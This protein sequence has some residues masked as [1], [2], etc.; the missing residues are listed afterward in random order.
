MGPANSVVGQTQDVE[1]I[2]IFKICE[3]KKRKIKFQEDEQFQLRN[4]VCSPDRDGATEVG[5]NFYFAFLLN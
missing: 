5:I 1:N 4:Y 3:K 2:L